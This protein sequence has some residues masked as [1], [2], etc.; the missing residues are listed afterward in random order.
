LS[1]ST[2]RRKCCRKVGLTSSF[3]PSFPPSLVTGRCRQGLEVRLSTSLCLLWNAT[4]CKPKC[5][6]VS[7]GFR[8]E[9][10][11]RKR[12]RWERTGWNV[13][14]EGRSAL[15]GR[16][17]ERKCGRKPTNFEWSCST[18]MLLSRFDLLPP[19]SASLPCPLLKLLHLRASLIH[20]TLVYL[21]RQLSKKQQPYSSFSP[22]HLVKQDQAT[23]SDTK[24]TRVRGSLFQ[25]LK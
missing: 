19:S 15:Y 22:P 3:F 16:L 6:R 9:S 8:G 25:V 20:Y 14:W 24:G 18:R 2:R 13:G 12:C 23:S 17:S 11:E 10:E 1:L 21:L 5:R 7:R 4:G